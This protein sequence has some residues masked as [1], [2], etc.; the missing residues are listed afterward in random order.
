MVRRSGVLLAVFEL[1]GH[2][3]DPDL[4]HEIFTFYLLD[5]CVCIYGIGYLINLLLNKLCFKI[6]VMRFQCFNRIS[7]HRD[8]DGT[9]NWQIISAI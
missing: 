9:A 3:F 4:R 1:V 6:P 5:L 8:Y 2:G 7:F